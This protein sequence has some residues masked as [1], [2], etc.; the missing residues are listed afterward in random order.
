MGEGKGREEGMH[1]EVRGGDSQTC[2]HIETGH[3]QWR[4]GTVKHASTTLLHNLECQHMSYIMY[5]Y[6]ESI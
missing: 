2:Q 5:I 3:A 4:Q 1:R 6:I